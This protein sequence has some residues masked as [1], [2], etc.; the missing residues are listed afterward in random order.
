MKR[1]LALGLVFAFLMAPVASPLAAAEVEFD[2]ASVT[3]IP[4]VECEALVALYNSTNGPAWTYSTNWLVTTTPS[5]WYGV[6]VGGLH[7]TGLDLYHNQLSGAIP[8]ELGNLTNLQ[9]LHLSYNQLNESI[10]P[11]LGNLTTC[12]A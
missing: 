5:N 4:Q 9:D 12:R 10:P 1:W 11:E 6:S 3:E 7:V 2:C 8:A